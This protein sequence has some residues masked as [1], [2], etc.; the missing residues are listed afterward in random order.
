MKQ[1]QFVPHLFFGM[2]QNGNL[3][4]RWEIHIFDKIIISKWLKHV[5]RKSTEN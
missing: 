2:P 1:W 4:L 5:I 3:A